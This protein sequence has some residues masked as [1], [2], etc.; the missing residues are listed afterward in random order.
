MIEKN[1]EVI[2]IPSVDSENKFEE[3]KFLDC[4]EKEKK[5]KKTDMVKILVS[6]Y[7]IFS[8]SYTVNIRSQTKRIIC[9]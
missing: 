2:L 4:I 5:D 6:E 1:S 9:R 7:L 8:L 3:T